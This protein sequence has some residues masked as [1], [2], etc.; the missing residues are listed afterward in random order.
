MDLIITNI[1]IIEIWVINRDSN[2]N[3]IENT[4]GIEI[5]YNKLIKEKRTKTI[6]YLQIIQ[7]R[8]INQ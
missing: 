2:Q 5:K 8:D 1:K 7:K 4:I 3:I 6:K